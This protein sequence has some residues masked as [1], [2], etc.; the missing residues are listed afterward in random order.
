MFSRHRQIL[1][2]ASFLICL[3]CA[4]SQAYPKYPGVFS[5]TYLSEY[6]GKQA[7]SCAICHDKTPDKYPLNN[8]GEA[9]SEISKGKRLNSE[10][11]IRSALRDTEPKPSAVPGKT[12]GD[13]IKEGKAPSSKK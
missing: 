7:G 6:G 12:F 11:A 4:Q 3:P 1:A 10:D 9:M 13:L 2:L 8:Y 5:S